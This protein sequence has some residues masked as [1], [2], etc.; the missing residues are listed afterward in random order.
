MSASDRPVLCVVGAG[1]AG[2]EALLAARQRLGTSIELRLI[3]PNGAFQYRPIR[4]GNTFRPVPERSL[5]IADVTAELAADWVPDRVAAVHGADRQLLTRDGELVDFDYLLIAAGVS[6][7]RTLHQGEVW[8]RGHDPRFLER[9]VDDTLS[10]EVQSIAVVIP[11]GARWPVPAYE[12]ALIL[13]W[14]AAG[15]RTQ[16]TLITSEEHPLAALGTNASNLVLHELRDAGVHLKTGV[17]VVDEPP[18]R[19]PRESPGVVLIPERPDQLPDALTGRPA[20]PA[21][22]RLG[23]G[24]EVEF[25]RLIS[26][27]A[28]TGPA[29][30]GVPTD[31]CGFIA[32]DDAFKVRGC[33]RIWAAGSCIAAAL[34]HS[35][36]AAEQ[37][38]AAIIEIEAAISG[39][40]APASREALRLPELTGILL[41]GQREQWLL[42]NPPGGAEIS[43][44]CL[45]WPPGRAV[46]HLLAQR[47]CA[48]DPST[49]AALAD[50]PPGLPI[51]VPVALAGADCSSSVAGPVSHDARVAQRRD[52]ENR[53]LMAVRR[54]EREA[55]AELRALGARLQ[56]LK[57]EQDDTIRELKAHGYLQVRDA[58][59]PDGAHRHA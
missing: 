57:R 33:H 11:R 8:Q 17:E 40:A 26:L 5:G 19:T 6:S 25:D 51:R 15:T 44:R 50:A 20:D 56:S 29:I 21:R 31:A 43:T 10:G 2:L 54:R 14:R 39:A 58:P 32:V 35:A 38:D 49:L 4:Q 27:P 42:Q 34:E 7:H 59:V 47:I 28:A 52:I 1:T 37:A 24:D 18:D 41:S 16:I 30:A 3:A 46:G 55:G 53:Q 9:I 36:L 12:L 48:G 23:A 45:W 22:V 13:A